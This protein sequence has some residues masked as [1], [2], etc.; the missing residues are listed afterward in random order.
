MADLNMENQEPQSKTDRELLMDN[1]E[2]PPGKISI[3]EDNP[4]SL[5]PVHL[6]EGHLFI[7]SPVTESSIQKSHTG[8]QDPLRNMLDLTMQNQDPQ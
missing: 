8:R 2:I 7:A 5:G 3:E 4:N 1:Q 6:Q